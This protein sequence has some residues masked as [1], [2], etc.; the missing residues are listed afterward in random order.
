[1]ILLSVVPINRERRK[2]K[3]KKKNRKKKQ[4]T[5]L[6]I[7]IYSYVKITV[8]RSPQCAGGGGTVE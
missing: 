3:W 8:V 7:Y 6:P 2:E 5:L 1:M 4:E